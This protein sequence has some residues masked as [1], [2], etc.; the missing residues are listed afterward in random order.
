MDNRKI[1]IPIN[2]VINPGYVKVVYGEGMPKP[3]NPSERGDLH[4]H[5]NIIFPK[6]L[7]DEQKYA[8]TKILP[9]S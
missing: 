1:R 7:T 8:L 6:H 9:M 3:K 2:E 5:F 4:I